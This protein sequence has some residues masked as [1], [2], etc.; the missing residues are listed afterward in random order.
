[1]ASAGS[2][3]FRIPSCKPMVV[4]IW[5]EIICLRSWSA[6]AVHWGWLSRGGRRRCYTAQRRG[7]FDP[8][9]PQ[10]GR[11]RLRALLLWLFFCFLACWIFVFGF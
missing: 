9:G 5:F 7:V 2:N 11:L 3:R 8:N 6:A 1:L 10:W 4:A